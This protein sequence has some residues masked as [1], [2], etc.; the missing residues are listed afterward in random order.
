MGDLLGAGIFS[1]A[2]AMDDLFGAAANSTAV[3]FGQV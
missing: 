1:D 2:K 3:S